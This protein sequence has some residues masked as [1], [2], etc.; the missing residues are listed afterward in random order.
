MNQGLVYTWT[1]SAARDQG[2]LV[3]LERVALPRL[4]PV[5]P[6]EPHLSGTFVR[7]TNAGW[8]DADGP[9]GGAPRYVRVGCARPDEKGDFNFQPHCGGERVDRG[10]L[11]D[12]V[13]RQRHVESAHFGEVNAYF[14]LDRI[15]AYLAELLAEL[16]A[17][18]PPRVTAV[19]CAHDGSPPGGGVVRGG[20]IVAFQ[21]GH[22]RVPRSS[23]DI[24]EPTA[25]AVTGE[26]HL[27][28]GRRMMHGGALAAAAGHPYRHNAAHNAGT[29][30][31]EY[32]HHL[33][34]HTC[35][36]RANALRPPMEQSNRKTPTEEGTCDYWAA[37]ML[38]APH[39][40]AWHHPHDAS[41]VHRR[42]LVSRKTMADFDHRPG[43]DPHR[44]GTIWGAALW[45]FRMRMA[46]A[47]PDGARLADR[48]VLQAL[49]IIGGQ[50]GPERPPTPRA[51]SRARAGFGTAA[52][53][54]LEAE[55]RLHGGRFWLALTESFAQRGI[56]PGRPRTDGSGLIEAGG[57]AAA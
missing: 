14:H 22:Y 25:P 21:G 55:R 50:L 31:H 43:A 7:V 45:N 12:P 33:Q 29:L 39:I 36:F 4:Q 2:G 9:V 15:A 49:L 51:A 18:A 20:K 57:G 3:Q 54:L 19:V 40:W 11:A 44:N 5:G 28:P 17:P 53:A 10:P 13:L 27:G 56:H 37:A 6:E 35:D 41:T 46:A 23:Y 47:S 34:R 24:D 8:I 16:A 52:A 1:P 32:A 26:I 42:S 30:Y 48:I 38:E